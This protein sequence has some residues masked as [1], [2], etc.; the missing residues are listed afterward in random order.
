MYHYVCF[1]SCRGWERQRT[2]IHSFIYFLNICLPWSILLDIGDTRVGRKVA[3]PAVMKPT[4]KLKH[5]R[6]LAI[7]IDGETLEGMISCH[8]LPGCITEFY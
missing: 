6:I 7:L 3:V 5:A 2:L 1:F 4:E 8:S